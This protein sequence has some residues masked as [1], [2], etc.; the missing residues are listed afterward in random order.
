MEA[1][2]KIWLQS[3]KWFQRG[4][5]LKVW[6][7]K[8]QRS[9]HIFKL[10]QAFRSGKLKDFPD[11][12]FWSLLETFTDRWSHGTWLIL[13]CKYKHP[14]IEL[15]ILLFQAK[16]KCILYLPDIVIFYREQMMAL[17]LSGFTSS[18]KLIVKIN[19]DMP[20]A[21]DEALSRLRKAFLIFTFGWFVNL[22]FLIH[23]I[24]WGKH[25]SLTGLRTSARQPGYA[26]F[27]HAHP[28][29]GFLQTRVVHAS[30]SVYWLV[31]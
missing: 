4:S 31:Q 29:T 21:Q 9:L 27:S 10:P 3:S 25:H 7:D 8:G 23:V 20:A 30:N 26:Y 5:H 18:Y 17:W 13:R 16:I 19:A 24:I 14:R 15:K 2:Y 28:K 6:T 12:W 1:T 11:I 22:Q